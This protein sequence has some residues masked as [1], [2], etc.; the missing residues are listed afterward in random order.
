MEPSE[1]IEPVPTSRLHDLSTTF[2]LI[3]RIE[4]LAARS[5]RNDLA[6]LDDEA[7]RVNRGLERLLAELER[8]TN[9]RPLRPLDGASGF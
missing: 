1:A 5:A 7:R 3:E 8:P 6:R 4:Q 9:V 2:A